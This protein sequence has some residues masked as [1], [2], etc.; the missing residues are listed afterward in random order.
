ME[1]INAI[2]LINKPYKNED[3]IDFSEELLSTLL[4]LANSIPGVAYW[5]TSSGIYIWHNDFTEHHQTIF[6]L[7]A[8]CRNIVG[9]TDY[10]IFPQNVA[11]EYR[12]D[13][14]E[15]MISK[16]GIIKEEIFYDQDNLEQQMLIYK[17]PML[18]ITNNIVGVIGNIINI[19]NF[20]KETTNL[21]IKKVAEMYDAVLNP[22]KE[23]ILL[24]N[25][26]EVSG[27]SD[28]VIS[29]FSEVKCIVSDVFNKINRQ[30]KI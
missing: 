25:L 17:R 11:N 21:S 10:D 18:D 13:D 20:N 30:Q 24:I 29:L 27:D 26:I 28:C 6:K 19:T 7:P 15:A 5:K 3:N 4:N 16:N 14:L 8:H 1:R 2:S 9:K 12:K 23:I 22:L